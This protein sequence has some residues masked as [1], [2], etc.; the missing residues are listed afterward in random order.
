MKAK[1]DVCGKE[2]D[3]LLYWRDIKFHPE[4]LI[5]IFFCGPN[6]SLSYEEKRKI[7]IR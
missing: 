5:P 3:R 7:S 2:V 6:C 1:C 4:Q